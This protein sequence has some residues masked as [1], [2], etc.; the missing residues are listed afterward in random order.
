MTKQEFVYIMDKSAWTRDRYGHYKVEWKGLSYRLKV[1]ELSVR[2]EK[3]QPDGSWFNKASNYYKNLE[4]I[5]GR[6]IIQGRSI[7]IMELPA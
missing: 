6:I 3:R 7:P 4:F 5:A 2:Y 1:Q